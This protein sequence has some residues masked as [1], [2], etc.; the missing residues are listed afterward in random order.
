MVVFPTRGCP[1]ICC[2]PNLKVTA[3]MS[4]PSQ[5][6]LHR[7]LYSPFEKKGVRKEVS[8]ALMEPFALLLSSM[9]GSTRAVS[10]H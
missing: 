8:L 1:L 3:T 10:C 6:L 2:P 5:L 4:S 7:L 9:K